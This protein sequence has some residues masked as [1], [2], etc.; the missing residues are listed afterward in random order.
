MKLNL[1]DGPLLQIRHITKPYEVWKA[2]ENLYSPKGFS[3]EFLLCKELF[4]TTLEKSRYHMETYLNQI[5]RLYDQLTA[6]N[7]IIPEK[8][9]FAWVLNNLTFEYETLITTITQ[10]IRV[11]GANSIS[12]SDLLSNLIDESKR[13]K[14]RASDHEAALWV[15][16]FSNGTLNKDLYEASNKASQ[17]GS[18]KPSNNHKVTKNGKNK[19]NCDFY[20]KKGLF[21][22]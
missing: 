16:Q 18:N 22:N 5:K 9:I 8:V 2:L 7:I 6:K 4:D 13:I 15:G 17:K 14:N 1:Y 11:N 3:L 19:P 12:L 20:K 10:L 21:T